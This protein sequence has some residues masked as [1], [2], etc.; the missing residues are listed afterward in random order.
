MSVATKKFSAGI[1]FLSVGK[2]TVG[3][4]KIVGWKISLAI[5]GNVRTFPR[6]QDRKTAEAEKNTPR[7][8]RG[9]KISDGSKRFCWFE[10]KMSVGGK[11]C[12]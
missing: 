6:M 5:S 12:R 2:K 7:P 11:K 3:W 1:S 8:Y 4:N 10:K 9:E